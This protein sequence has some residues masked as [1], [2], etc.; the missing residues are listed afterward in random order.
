MPPLPLRQKTCHSNSRRWAGAEHVSLL[1][2]W[3]YTIAQKA[4]QLLFQVRHGDE[5]NCLLNIKVW[6]FF[7][8]M[9]HNTTRLPLTWAEELFPKKYGKDAHQELTITSRF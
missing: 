8:T 4:H 2:M 5:Q 6:H 9:C 3:C 7:A 1:L